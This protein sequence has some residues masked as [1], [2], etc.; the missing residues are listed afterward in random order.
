MVYPATFQRR[1][2]QKG[3]GSNIRVRLETYPRVQRREECFREDS[4]R[5]ADKDEVG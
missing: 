1:S 3:D 5:D 2:K 4:E